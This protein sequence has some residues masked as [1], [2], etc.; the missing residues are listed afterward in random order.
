MVHK[1]SKS[2][3]F[4]FALRVPTSRCESSFA[5]RQQVHRRSL[6]L[7]FISSS[8]FNTIFAQLKFFYCPILPRSEVW[9]YSLKH[10]ND[11]TILATCWLNLNAAMRPIDVE[12]GLLWIFPSRKR[13][14]ISIDRN[15]SVRLPCNDPVQPIALLVASAKLHMPNVNHVV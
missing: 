5:A 2:I 14:K 1:Q 8:N 11:R 4:S 3:K 15:R 12:F 10:W 13:S 7:I 6:K 9:T